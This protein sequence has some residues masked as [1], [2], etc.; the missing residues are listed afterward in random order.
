MLKKERFKFLS[1]YTIASYLV[2]GTV[3]ISVINIFLHGLV[4]LPDFLLAVF[5]L[6]LRYVSFV[7]IKRR[8]HWSK[9]LIV[10]LLLRSIYRLIQ[11]IELPGANS[12]YVVMLFLQIVL[13]LAASYLLFRPRRS[14]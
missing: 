9:Y 7:L 3:V 5:I 12:F 2:L 4:D 13:T 10:I 6:I 11:V 8:F 1:N 14:L